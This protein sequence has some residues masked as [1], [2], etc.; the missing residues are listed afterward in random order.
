M[1]NEPMRK[2]RK[3]DRSVID[4]DDDA[5]DEEFDSLAKFCEDTRAQV[6]EVHT[7]SQEIEN[8]LQT[9]QLENTL[10]EEKLKNAL[11][12]EVNLIEKGT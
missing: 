4:L 12:E 11:F 2:R 8:R 7:A 5:L 9:Q 10:L 1:L 3:L 6:I